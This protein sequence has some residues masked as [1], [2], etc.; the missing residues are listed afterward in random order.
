MSVA[1]SRVR[2]RKNLE[3]ETARIE[4]QSRGEQEKS[5]EKTY[6]DENENAISGKYF[7]LKSEPHEFGIDDLAAKPNQTWLWDGIRNFQA[8]KTLRSMNIGD[9]AFFYHSSNGKQTGIVGK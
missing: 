3:T 9:L 8:R 7:L 4:K 6:S 2:K 5:K 1:I